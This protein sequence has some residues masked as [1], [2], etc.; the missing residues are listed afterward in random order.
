[1]Y[2]INLSVILLPGVYKNLSFMAK[3]CNR[4]FSTNFIVPLE[5]TVILQY[6]KVGTC[7]YY[8][9]HLNVSHTLERVEM[10]LDCL[11]I[12]THSEG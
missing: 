3:N 2:G 1:M 7:M 5:W 10:Y 4:A 6:N 11:L 9:I 12:C 8:Q